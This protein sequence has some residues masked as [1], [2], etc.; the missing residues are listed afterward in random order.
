MSEFADL[1][2]IAGLL[3]NFTPL[4]ENHELYFICDQGAIN[5]ALVDLASTRLRPEGVKNAAAL[6]ER[7]ARGEVD[8]RKPISVAPR[9]DGKWDVLDGNS[10]VAVAR[11][12]RWHSIPCSKEEALG[13]S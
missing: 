9:P 12:S 13:T 1:E 2:V 10:T 7:A 11:L 5:I 8:R 4:Q 6:M 3:P